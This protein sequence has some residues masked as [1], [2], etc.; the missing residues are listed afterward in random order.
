MQ[1][2]E[3]RDIKSEVLPPSLFRFLRSHPS[4][5]PLR[6]LSPFPFSSLSTLPVSLFGLVVPLPPH[7]FLP[8]FPLALPIATSALND[9]SATA[10]L[11][12][13]TGALGRKRASMPGSW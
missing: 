9:R 12:V 8:P 1:Y 2:S 11:E 5:S 4:L 3:Q 6:P 10:K 13:F 7:H